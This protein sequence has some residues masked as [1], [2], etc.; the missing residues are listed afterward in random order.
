MT[1]RRPGPTVLWKY[2]DPAGALSVP[3]ADGE[4][5]VFNTIADNRVVALD[6]RSGAKQWERRLELPGQLR[7]RGFPPGRLVGAGD[8]VVV[9]AWDL[10]G[11]DKRTGAVRWK[12]APPDDFPGVDVMLGQDGYLY[13]T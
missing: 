7:N 13:S 12:F 10:Y 3:Y 8:I 9:P 5:A 1:A 2:R 11:L 4:V 6:A